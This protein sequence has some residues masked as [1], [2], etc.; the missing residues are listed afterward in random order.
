MEAGLELKEVNIGDLMFRAVPTGSLS[1]I[2]FNYSTR[3]TKASSI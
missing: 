1:A 3:K 2:S